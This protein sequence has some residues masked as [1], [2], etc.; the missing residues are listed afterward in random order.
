MN[1]ARFVVLLFAL[2][3]LAAPPRAGAQNKVHRLGVLSVS[4]ASIEA[5][6]TRASALLAK[7]GFAEGRNLVM[8]GRHGTV[9]EL[10]GLLREILA[11]KPDVILAIGGDAISLASRA[12]TT[13]PIVAYGP[14]LISLGV[15]E[16]IARPGGNVTGVVILPAELDGKRFALL[17]EALPRARRLAAL[18]HPASPN[19][20]ASEREMRAAAGTAFDVRFFYAA[21]PKD[22]ATAFGAMRAAE[23]QGVAILAHPEYFRD[24]A[25]LARHALAARLP[26]ICQWAEMA[27]EGCM[28]S[29]GPPLE[30]MRARLTYLIVR[31]FNGAKPSE[32]PIEQPTKVEFVV[33]LKT[34]RALGVTLPETMLLRADQVIE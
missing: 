9:E 3:V 2:A 4:V 14:D 15:A 20:L 34:A 21:G 32:L 1:L 17:Q 26:T 28:L 10:P 22:Y 6:A 16:S 30:E 18:A 12:T 5:T 24:R 8:I 7:E 19:R 11:A 23:V 13:V 31:I 33:N 27:A 25:L 29:Y